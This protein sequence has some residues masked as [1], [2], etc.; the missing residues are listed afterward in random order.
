MII[1]ECG[2]IFTM[3]TMDHHMEMENYYDGDYEHWTGI[4]T[5]SSQ[6]GNNKV[7]TCPNC[8]GNFLFF[9]LSFKVYTYLLILF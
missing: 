6:T 1:L 2:H 8:R 7:M 3:E 9:F 5:L 4:K